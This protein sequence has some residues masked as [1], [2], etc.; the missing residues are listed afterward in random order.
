MFMK[1]TVSG[2][3]KKRNSSAHCDSNKTK[4]EELGAESSAS[5]TVK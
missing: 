4:Q 1:V 3:K 5:G 2:H